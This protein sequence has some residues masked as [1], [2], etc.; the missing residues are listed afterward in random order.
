MASQDFIIETQGLVKRFNKTIST[1]LSFYSS[2][3]NWDE[4]IKPLLFAY[5]TSIHPAT[6][7]TPFFLVFGYDPLTPLNTCMDPASPDY[8][9]ENSEQLV[10]H[11]INQIFLWRKAQ[12][13]LDKTQ[14]AM[15]DCYNQSTR[16]TTMSVGSKVWVRNMAVPVGQSKKLIPKYKGPFRIAKLTPTTPFFVPLSEP[17]SKFHQVHLDHLKPYHP[18]YVP[19][20][21]TVPTPINTAE[22]KEPQ[23]NIIPP[24]PFLQPDPQRS[25][26][27]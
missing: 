15:A 27:L 3:E 6:G 25:I 9:T 2:S 12:A 10:D 13:E 5:R 16:P 19:L 7:E 18:S 22:N 26:E 8:L 11:A 24:Q 4:F 23:S 20:E 14:K 17:S 21:L 1:I